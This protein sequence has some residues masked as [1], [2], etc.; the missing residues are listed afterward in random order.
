M[1]EPDRTKPTIQ[2]QAWDQAI[3]DAEM[4]WIAARLIAMEAR[5]RRLCPVDEAAER[6]AKIGVDLTVAQIRMIYKRGKV[7]T[8]KVQRFRFGQMRTIRLVDPKEL[9]HYATLDRGERIAHR[10]WM[11]EDYLEGYTWNTKVGMS[12]ISVGSV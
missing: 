11:T 1:R 10:P 8:E 4:V 7:Y 9:A 3:S 5:R 12:R 6:L 2:E